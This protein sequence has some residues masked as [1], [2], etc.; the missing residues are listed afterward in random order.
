MDDVYRDRRD[1]ALTVA[2]E[3]ESGE[4]LLAWT[5][6][7]WTLPANLALAVAPDLEY[8]VVERGGVRYVLAAAR[9]A[10]YA[11]E[12]PDEPVEIVRGAELVG[13]RYRPLF[14]FFA[15]TSN[16]FQV[17]GA[18][19]VSTEE[20]TGIV[21]LAP[22]FGEDDQQAC[23]A[24]DIPTV[25]PMDEHGRYTAEVA[26]WAG[27]HVFDANPHVTERL[28]EQGAVLRAET[29]DHSY[30]HCWRCEQPL[31][32]RAISS[33]FVEVTKFRERMVELNEQI[34]WVPDH[35]KHGSFG[36]WLENARDWSISRN[37]FWG[38]PI[39]VWR[40]DDPAHPR[41]TCTD[42]WPNWRPTSVS[43]SPTCTGR[44]STSSCGRIPTTRPDG[45]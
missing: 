39:P 1:P 26:P 38:S 8:A 14:D 9:L 27:Q 29:Y 6:T 43:P 30:P 20:G 45:R 21:H 15:D 17:L 41:S 33:W 2:F 10:A 44:W 36:K 13:R 5:T 3:L 35:L 12:F 32:Y 28:R 11:D 16:A 37:R 40:S 4:R 23:N 34:T 42:R 19:F 24:V 18:D 25:V 7:P 22:G 31:V